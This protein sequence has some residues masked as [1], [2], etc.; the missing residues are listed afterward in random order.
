MDEAKFHEF[1]VDLP[2]VQAASKV[3]LIMGP[4][5]YYLHNFTILSKI[6]EAKFF[7][8]EKILYTTVF[9]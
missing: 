5:L 4:S 7:G 1:E 9:Y 6:T 2:F 8:S 3:R